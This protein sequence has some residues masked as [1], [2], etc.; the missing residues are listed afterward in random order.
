[1]GTPENRT[2][3]WRNRADARPYTADGNPERHLLR[4]PQRMCLE[5]VAPLS[6]SVA[7][8][9]SLLLVMAAERNMT[10][11]PG[12]HAGMGAQSSRTRSGTERCGPRQR[13]GAD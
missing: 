12:Q 10:A 7:Y 6:A 3:L 2:S 9:L 1:M 11:D 13:V 5:T 8:C 4:S